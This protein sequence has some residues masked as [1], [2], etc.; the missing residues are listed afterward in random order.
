MQKVLKLFKKIK[1]T[2]SLEAIIFI[3]AAIALIMGVLLLI[4][5][6]KDKYTKPTVVLT[7]GSVSAGDTISVPVEFYKCEG[8]YVAGLYIEYDA[9]NLKYESYTNGDIFD[10]CFVNVE[11]AGKLSIILEMNGDETV[12]DEGTAVT[13][14]F[15]A[16]ISAY[17]GEYE[18]ILDQDV[19]DDE[20]CCQVCT[21]DSATESVDELKVEYINGKITVK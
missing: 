21:F 12:K 5:F 15:K 3:L 6:Q 18:L 20:I 16:K 19:E 17:K 4:P 7:G 8:A 2:I 10:L 1:E 9:D 14:K 13:L 11:E